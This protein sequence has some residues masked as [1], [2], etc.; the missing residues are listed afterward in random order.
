MPELSN[1]GTR[2]GVMRLQENKEELGQIID[3]EQNQP[4]SN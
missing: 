3:E 2:L 4:K 1:A